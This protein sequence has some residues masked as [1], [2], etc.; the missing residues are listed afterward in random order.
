MAGEIFQQNPQI[1]SGWPVI[2]SL[3]T[4]ETIG[5]IHRRIV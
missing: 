2:R 3:H 4:L 1:V 5:R